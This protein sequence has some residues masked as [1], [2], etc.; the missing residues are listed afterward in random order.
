MTWQ[1]NEDRLFMLA[2]TKNGFLELRMAGTMM[3][4]S[5]PLI[6]VGAPEE[7]HWSVVI[8]VALQS[9]G[10]DG[11]LLKANK[12]DWFFAWDKHRLSQSL[13]LQSVKHDYISRKVWWNFLVL[14]VQMLP[15][16]SDELRQMIGRC[17]WSGCGPS[18]DVCRRPLG[19][20]VVKG[21][22]CL[23]PNW[24]P[25]GRSNESRNAPPKIKNLSRLREI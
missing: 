6:P 16:H 4:L 19:L 22:F 21:I 14:Q 12:S 7:W 20:G 11:C 3:V 9:A 18:G 13:W 23:A 5:I 24:R 10:L 17:T 15:I 1:P 2:H 25:L 8:S